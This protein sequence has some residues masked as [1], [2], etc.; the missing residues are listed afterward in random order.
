L[1]ENKNTN[2]NNSLV[3]N[4]VVNKNQTSD[5]VNNINDFS[6]IEQ[7]NTQQNNLTDNVAPAIE[8]DINLNQTNQTNQT[9]QNQNNVSYSA[10]IKNKKLYSG[11]KIFVLIVL[12][13][14]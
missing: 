7:N 11:I 8:N 3:D 5:N 1:V 2:I 10:P 12:L 6:G 9:N 14:V 13:I 4:E